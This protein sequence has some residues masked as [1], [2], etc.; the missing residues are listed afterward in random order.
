M[1]ADR[2]LLNKR[3]LDA[4]RKP[5]IARSVQ[6]SSPCWLLQ[7]T[8]PPVNTNTRKAGSQPSLMRLTNVGSEWCTGV[9]VYVA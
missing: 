5:V 3:E 8:V 2:V 9:T 4:Q 6:P 1:P 7:A